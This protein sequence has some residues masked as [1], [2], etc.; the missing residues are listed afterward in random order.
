MFT[1]EQ[2]FEQLKAM[3][4]PQNK[5]VTTHTSLRNIGDVEGRGEG[6][7]NILIIWG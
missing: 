5:P 4:V 7:L 3:G 6:L 1:K 2:I